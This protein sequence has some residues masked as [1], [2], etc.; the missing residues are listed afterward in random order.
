MCG[1]STS[2]GG[3]RCG[4]AD[5]CAAAENAPSSAIDVSTQ[6]E[7]RTAR[8]CRAWETG[9]T[10]TSASRQWHV[11][12]NEVPRRSLPAGLKTVP[13]PSGPICSRVTTADGG[14]PGSRVIAAMTSFRDQDFRVA[15]DASFAACT[16][17]DSCAL[18]SCPSRDASG[19]A[20]PFEPRLWGTV[21]ITVG[22]RVWPSQSRRRDLPA[23]GRYRATP[24]CETGKVGPA[25]FSTLLCTIQNRSVRCAVSSDSLV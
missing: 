20:F 17:G 3:S 1:G 7:D 4:E 18:R 11:T 12:A 16:S 21:V 13:T 24:S 2:T 22:V 5:C 6:D 23:I 14:C 9:D 8:Q 25:Y 15:Y 19:A 10:W